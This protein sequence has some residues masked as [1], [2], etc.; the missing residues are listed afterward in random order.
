[1]FT[2]YA[3]S[4]ERIDEIAAHAIE[5]G[6]TV[7]DYS[8]PAELIPDLVIRHDKQG[9]MGSC[10]GFGNTTIGE[11]ALA[12]QQRIES[13]K[14]SLQFSP[15]FAYLEAQRFDGLIGSDKGCTISACVRVAKEI[16][17]LPESALAYRTPYP[18]NARSIVT[19]EMRAL[20]A[21][22]RIQSHTVIR[23]YDGLFNYLAS[24][25]GGVLA[26][27]GWNNSFY[28]P[29]GGALERV[30]LGY[31]DGGHAYGFVG[32]IR[33]QDARGRNYLLRVNSHEDFLTPVAP[34]VIDQL[35]SSRQT[36]MVGLSDMTTP[37]PR[38][39]NFAKESVLG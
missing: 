11:Y 26:G 13:W 22:N 21:P 38:N 24:R 30:S 16:G 5:L 39:V 29:R 33:R 9:N 35:F 10:G 1:M 32:Y 23:D 14:D 31:M 12:R 37:R 8:P 18:R 19:D 15:L 7:R 20:A 28:A 4:H 3:I 27:T 6:F 17:Y 2:G 25:A 36:V 34:A